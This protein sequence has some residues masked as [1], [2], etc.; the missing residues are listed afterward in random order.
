MI[1]GAAKGQGNARIVLWSMTLAN[2]MILIDQTAV[3][4]AL[5]N[6]MQDFGVGSQQ[7]QW[8]LNASLL[9]LRGRPYRAGASPAGSLATGCRTGR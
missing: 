3:P 2:A 7:G 8:V 4:L 5:P 6:V 1:L 9:L